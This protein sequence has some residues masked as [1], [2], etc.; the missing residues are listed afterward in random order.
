MTLYLTPVINPSRTL[1]YLYYYTQVSDGSCA[2][3]EVNYSVYVITSEK[4]KKEVSRGKLYSYRATL[5]ER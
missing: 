3:I 4:L 1:P 5:F 2:E